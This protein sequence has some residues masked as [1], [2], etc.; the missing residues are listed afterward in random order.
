MPLNPKTIALANKHKNYELTRTAT[1]L[2]KITS[3]ETNQKTKKYHKLEF[4]RSISVKT[5]H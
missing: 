4:I 5:I 2:T 1:F 3:Y